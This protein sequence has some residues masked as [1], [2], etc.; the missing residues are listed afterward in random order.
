MPSKRRREYNPRQAA[1]TIQRAWK[2]RRKTKKI[3]RP[4]ALKMHNFVERCTPSLMTVAQESSAT[5]LFRSFTLSQC[6]QVSHY[7]ELFEYYKINKVV[8]EFRYKGAATPAYTSVPASSSGTQA[9]YAMEIKNEINPILYF[10]VDHN[11]ETADSLNTLK[12]STRTREHQFTNDKPNFT[13]QIKPA[14]LGEAYKTAIA[15]AYR[16][17]W[18]QWL[19]TADDTVPHYGFKAYAVAGLGNNVNMGQIE[20]QQK[21]YFSVKCNE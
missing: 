17:K 2:R 20:V 4:L 3:R 8:L 12:E 18:N 11:D 7:K 21:I 14:I 15:T 1:Q 10:K 19:S 5:G 16:P 9:A 6:L 13:I